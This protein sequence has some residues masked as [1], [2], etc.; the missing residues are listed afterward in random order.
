M[1]KKISSFVDYFQQYHESVTNPEGYWA[2]I[3]DTF[4]WHKKWDKVLDWNFT[5]PKIKWFDGGKLNITENIFERNLPARKDQ[6]ALIW[7]PNDPKEPE[8]RITYGELFEKVC[9]FANAL[10]RQGIQKGDRVAIYLPMV[11]ELPIAM[12]ACARIGA[13]HS[14]VFAG[15]SANS[16]ADRINDSACKM[17]ITADGL[18]RGSKNVGLKSIV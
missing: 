4:Q 9:I 5:E 16:L 6:V 12:L 11:P 10:K 17:V 3:A 13:I 1:M 7:E 14:I 15:F 8:K 2:K 18:Y